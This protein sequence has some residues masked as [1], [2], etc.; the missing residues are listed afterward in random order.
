MNVFDFAMKMELDGK[1][2]YEK[3]AKGTNVAGLQTIFTR[4]AADEQKHYE[5]FLALKGRTQ[6]T[7]MEETTVLED[8]KNVFEALLEQKDVLLVPPGSSVVWQL[9]QV[10]S[11]A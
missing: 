9:E 3:L 2:F 7:A 6:A 4:L 10:T 11:T 1:A 8:A 5:T